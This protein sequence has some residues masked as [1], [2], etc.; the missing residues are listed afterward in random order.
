M[1]QGESRSATPAERARVADF[2]AEL[3]ARTPAEVRQKFR[4]LP[5]ET[6]RVLAADFA[7]LIRQR[8]DEDEEA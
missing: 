3:F 8:L 1:I 6:L 5:S 2:M 4:R 7:D